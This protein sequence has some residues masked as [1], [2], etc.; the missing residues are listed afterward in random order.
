MSGPQNVWRD[1]RALNLDESD[2][3]SILATNRIPDRYKRILRRRYGLFDVQHTLSEIAK[4]ESVTVE[5]IRQIIAVSLIR[6]K[7]YKQGKQ[8]RRK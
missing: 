2:L 7:R 8:L 4:E 1:A 3:V 5:R 6:A